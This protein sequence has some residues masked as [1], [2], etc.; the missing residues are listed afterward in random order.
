MGYYVWLLIFSFS[1]RKKC[2]NV[3]ILILYYSNKIYK[4]SNCLSFDYYVPGK[5]FYR[6][7]KVGSIFKKVSYF[8]KPLNLWTGIPS[9]IDAAVYLR[10]YVTTMFFKG[11]QYYMYSDRECQVNRIYSIIQDIYSKNRDTN[12]RRI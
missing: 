10:S 4:F 12:H 6:V 9:E 11:G 7:S 1:F 3:F 8:P 5:L 2:L